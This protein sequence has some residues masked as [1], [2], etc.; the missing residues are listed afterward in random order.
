[1]HALSRYARISAMKLLLQT[2]SRPAAGNGRHFPA[3]FFSIT[4]PKVARQ[5][6]NDLSR[7]SSA[8]LARYFN[9]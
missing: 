8:G 7:G 4:G 9:A 5:A 3:V 2:P 6:V 1:M